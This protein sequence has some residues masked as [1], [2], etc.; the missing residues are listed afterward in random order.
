M[1][2]I[3]VEKN[4]SGIRIDKFLSKEFFSLSRGEIIK[5]IK[6][7]EILV[8]DALVKPSY[9]LKEGDMIKSTVS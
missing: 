7:K 4:K 8:N 1:K 6:E 5:N 3:R 2:I 9:K